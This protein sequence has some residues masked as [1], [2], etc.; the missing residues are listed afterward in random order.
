[1]RVQ[2][3]LPGLQ[4]R[5]LNLAETMATPP[6][7][8]SRVRRLSQVLPRGWKQLLRL[9]VTPAGLEFIGPPPPAEGLEMLDAETHR[10]RWRELLD[11]QTRLYEESDG[12]EEVSEAKQKVRRML[13]LLLNYQMLEDQVVSRQLAESQG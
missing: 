4:P 12:S 8:K 11:R 7:F 2:Y 13:S 3:T 9:D 5:H 6:S 10:Q 1:M